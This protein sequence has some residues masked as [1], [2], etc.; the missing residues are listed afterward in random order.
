[1]WDGVPEG[2]AFSGKPQER[3]ELFMTAA[4][5]S[6]RFNIESAV[7]ETGRKVS[8]LI[9]DAFFWF[10]G[11]IAQGMGVPS[12]IQFWTA[13]PCSL[14]AHFYTDLIRQQIATEPKG[15]AFFGF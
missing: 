13:G 3:I 10:G 14:S 7:A 2:Y 11:E 8:C 4:L 1:M 6:L 9:T 15:I 5:E 12:W